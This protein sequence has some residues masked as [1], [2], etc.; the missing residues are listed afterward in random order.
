M[1]LRLDVLEDLEQ[2]EVEVELMRNGERKSIGA[3]GVCLS[4]IESQ[5]YQKTRL[6]KITSQMKC[7]QAI[8][9]KYKVFEGKPTTPIQNKNLIQVSQCDASN[10]GAQEN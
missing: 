1:K 4:D 2:Y 5:H 6:R 9:I 3:F 8:E 10:L 7:F